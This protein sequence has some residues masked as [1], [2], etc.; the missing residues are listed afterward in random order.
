MLCGSPWVGSRVRGTLELPGKFGENTWKSTSGCPSRASRHPSHGVGVGET[1]ANLHHRV[2]TPRKVQEGRMERKEEAE[3]ARGPTDLTTT[4]GALH[5]KRW[6][7][8]LL[9]SATADSQS[10]SPC[11]FRLDS[12]KQ[13]DVANMCSS[14]QADA[15]NMLTP[16][17]RPMKDYGVPHGNGIKTRNIFRIGIVASNHV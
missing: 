6:T 15:V 4:L 12:V 10:K 9:S 3:G 11:A 16:M 1:R 2:P 7:K 14:S 8:H 5:D 17:K 13:I